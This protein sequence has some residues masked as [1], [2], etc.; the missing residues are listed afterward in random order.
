VY[1]GSLAA[2]PTP[3]GGWRVEV[4]LPLPSASEQKEVA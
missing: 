4:R 1:D 2:G 3:A